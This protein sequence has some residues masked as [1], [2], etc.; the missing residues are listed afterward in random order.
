MLFRF[1]RRSRSS[2][3]HFTSCEVRRRLRQ[4][5]AADPRT[6][7]VHAAAADI[8]TWTALLAPSTA[9]ELGRAA[10][11]LPSA[12][13]WFV[14]GRSM[15]DIGQRLRPLGGPWDAEYAIDVASCL[16]ARLLN[17]RAHVELSDGARNTRS[18]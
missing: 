1:L 12:V 14:Q 11:R 3:L 8:G 4:Q 17:D 13:F 6:A 16:I 15:H 9:H 7:T 10:E 18:A 2:E 5:P